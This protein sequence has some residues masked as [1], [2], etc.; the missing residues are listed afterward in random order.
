M[1]TLLAALM[2]M[3]FNATQCFAISGGPFG[4][5]TTQVSV[6]GTYAGVLIPIQVEV[7]PGP[8]PVFLPPDNS[9]VLFTMRIP[10]TGLATGTSAVFRNGFFYPGTIQGL[11]DPDSARL[12]GLVNAFFQETVAQTSTTDFIF[13]YNANGQFLN[14]KIVA[15]TNGVSVARIKGKASLTYTNDAGDPGGD[16]GGPIQYKIRG[17][18]QSTSTT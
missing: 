16:S 10:T 18:K 3:V 8:P 17:F 1:K 4:G 7:D 12:T 9:L 5:G 14:A 2:C 6:T 11:A 13:Q 15:N